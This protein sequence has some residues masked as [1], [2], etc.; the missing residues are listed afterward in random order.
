MSAQPREHEDDLQG[1]ALRRAWL[2]ASYEVRQEPGPMAA[3]TYGVRQGPP[4]SIRTRA[5]SYALAVVC[6]AIIYAGVWLVWRMF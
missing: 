5:I 2:D 6:G 3:K 4:V 1:E